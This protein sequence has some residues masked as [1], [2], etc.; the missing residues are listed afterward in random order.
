MSIGVWFAPFVLPG[1]SRHELVANLGKAPGLDS[2]TRRGWEEV[3]AI[4]SNGKWNGR[5]QGGGSGRSTEDRR[6]AKRVGR[7]GPGPE[8]N[9]NVNS[10]AGVR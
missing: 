3:V 9:A 2:R 7:E 6:A 5:D 10:E 8:S 4:T 1:G